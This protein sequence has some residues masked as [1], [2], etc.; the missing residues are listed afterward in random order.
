MS[1]LKKFVVGLLVL[2]ALVVVIGL[3]LPSTA[4]VERSVQIA[5]A[6]HVVF[7]LV[8]NLRNFNR[9]SPW[10]ERDPETVYTFSGPDAGVGA[11]MS[12]A[13][14]NPQVG[15]G[16][17]R[18]TT[19]QPHSRVEAQLDFGAQ[20]TAESFFDLQPADDG[21]AVTWGFDTDFGLDLVGRYMGLMFDSWIGADYEAGLANLKALA[22]S[23]PQTNWT[24][25]E[26]E[27][28]EL[29]PFLVAY[30]TGASSWD[31]A[32]I[33]EDLGSAY[34][35]IGQFIAK[36]GLEPPGPPLTVSRNLLVE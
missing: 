20:G 18:L 3:F 19:S 12:W 15:A 26:I 17:Q 25:L 36:Q 14:D 23:L 4:H 10:A 22:E 21:T 28:I 35:S 30:T 1:L 34:G 16:S 6:P 27:V 29:D 24:D 13:S 5:A 9:W 7:T 11:T 31:A 32:E 2:V 33:S 8:D